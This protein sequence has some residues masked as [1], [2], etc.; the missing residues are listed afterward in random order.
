MFIA[1]SEQFVISVLG[2]EVLILNIYHIY[3]Y[4]D[5]LR[6]F[7]SVRDPFFLFF[8]GGE[9]VKRWGKEEK[10]GYLYKYG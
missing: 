7:G 5:V 2:L 4:Y 3:K 6:V 8:F 1:K 10:M 9:M